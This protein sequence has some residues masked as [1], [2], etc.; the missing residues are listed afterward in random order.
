MIKNVEI[1]EMYN[2]YLIRRNKYKNVQKKYNFEIPMYIL[3]EMIK[4]NYDKNE[5]CLLINMAKINNR[6]TED[7]A[8]LLK[9]DYH[10]K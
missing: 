2:Q 3:S 5:L 6:F 9:Y 7:E 4:D 10:I 8:D 1:E